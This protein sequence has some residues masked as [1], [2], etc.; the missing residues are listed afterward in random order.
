MPYTPEETKRRL[1]AAAVDEFS[2]N[3]LA[4][5]RVDRIAQAA[6]A[7]KE[8]IYAYFGDKEGLFGAA[9]ESTLLAVI[10]AVAIEGSGIDAVLDYAAAVFDY[11]VAHPELSRLLAWE[12]LERTSPVAFEARSV[13]HANK[14]TQLRR[15]LPE[16]DEATA[17]EL[18]L[19]IVTLADGWQ[20]F[21]SLDQLYSGGRTDLPERIAERRVFVLRAVRALVESLLSDAAAQD[22]DR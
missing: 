20:V 11:Q 18:L 6:D 14:V 15:V 13:S 12:G 1:L 17:I 19:T 22:A 7:N 5:A 2:A 8:R 4:G 3:G 16:L 9:L 10:H 21:R